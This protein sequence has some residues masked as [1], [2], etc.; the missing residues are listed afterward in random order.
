MEVGHNPI[1]TKEKIKNLK[2]MRRGHRLIMSDGIS[3]RLMSCECCKLAV[4]GRRNPWN[5]IHYNGRGWKINSIYNFISDNNCEVFERKKFL[6]TNYGYI[7]DHFKLMKYLENPDHWSLYWDK[8]R[9]H[10]KKIGLPERK[11]VLIYV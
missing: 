10:D 3:S 11:T 2:C 1:V 6:S 7:V 5:E 9:E 4:Y 8:K